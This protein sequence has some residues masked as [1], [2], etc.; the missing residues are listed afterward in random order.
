MSPEDA[1]KKL[2]WVKDVR[3]FFLC[4]HLETGWSLR[5]P[6]LLNQFFSDSGDSS[7]FMEPGSG[8]NKGELAHQM[9]LVLGIGSVWNL[10]FCL[11]MVWN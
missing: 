2:T 5:S 6:G 11:H 9:L 3:L 8:E 7:D 10:D 4:D 1:E